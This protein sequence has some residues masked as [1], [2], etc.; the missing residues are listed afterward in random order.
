MRKTLLATLSLVV[1]SLPSCQANENDIMA[2]TGVIALN[3]FTL[4]ILSI[5]SI[6]SFLLGLIKEK[7]QAFFLIIGIFIGVIIGDAIIFNVPLQMQYTVIGGILGMGT[8]LATS[9]RNRNGPQ[10]AVNSLARLVAGIAKTGNTAL[11]EAGIGKIS[12][13]TVSL[14]LWSLLF[15]VLFML[16]TGVALKPIFKRV[17]T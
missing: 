8:D 5:M 3:V 1:F 12:E 6:V 13:K 9:L 11:R 17:I 7:W 4:V 10:T 2:V 14:F 15:T 16:L